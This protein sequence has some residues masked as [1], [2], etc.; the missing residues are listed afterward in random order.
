MEGLITIVNGIV[1]RWRN[2]SRTDTEGA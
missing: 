1:T 2:F